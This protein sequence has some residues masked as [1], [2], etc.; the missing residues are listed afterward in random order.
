MQPNDQ[1]IRAW[2]PCLE[3]QE[4][5]E[6]HLYDIH[7]TNV[8]H[9]ACPSSALLACSAWNLVQIFCLG[10]TMQSVRAKSRQSPGQKRRGMDGGSTLAYDVHREHAMPGRSDRTFVGQDPCSPSR[11]K[12]NNN[13]ALRRD[14]GSSY[15]GTGTL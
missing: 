12:G 8:P 11:G 4:A 10:T 13:D 6:A 3:F 1:G 14:A 2:T 7:A 9:M 15:T 5:E